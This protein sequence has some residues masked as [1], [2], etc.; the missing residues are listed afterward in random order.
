MPVS[1]LAVRFRELRSQSKL[2]LAIFG[3]PGT[4]LLA[5]ERHRNLLTAM[6]KAG[7]VENILIMGK[8]HAD[9][10][11]TAR[12]EKLQ[13]SIGGSWRS[14]FDA[15]GEKIADELACCHL[16]VAANAAG[17]ITKSGVFAAFAANGVVPL[18]WNSDGCAVPDVFREC[19]L[20]NDDSAETCRRLLEDLR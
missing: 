16:G 5:L 10:V 3:M 6:V 18:V 11:Q 14:V 4:R 2:K 17:L 15:A 1:P 7:I 8:A 12:L 13:R 20:L 9:D 19:V